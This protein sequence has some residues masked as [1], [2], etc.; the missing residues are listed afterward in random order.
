MVSTGT[1]AAVV[2]AKYLSLVVNN[3]TV[4]GISSLSSMCTLASNFWMWSG[5]RMYSEL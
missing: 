4:L 3:V 1:S 2:P 5:L